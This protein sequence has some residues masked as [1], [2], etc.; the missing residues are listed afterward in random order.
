MV[1]GYK[2]FQAVEVKPANPSLQTVPVT[3]L[4]KSRKK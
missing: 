1:S 2:T 3:D 4:L